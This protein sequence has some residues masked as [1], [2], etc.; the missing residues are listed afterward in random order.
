MKQAPSSDPLNRTLEPPSSGLT[1]DPGGDPMTPQCSGLA[2][3]DVACCLPVA[4]DTLAERCR[5]QRKKLWC[6]LMRPAGCANRAI[7]M[8]R[9]NDPRHD[10]LD[11]LRTKR[12]IFGISTNKDDVRK[13]EMPE[14]KVATLPVD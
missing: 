12:E 7:R 5:R 13:I 3:V 2:P 4:A 11:A 1:P 10:Q 6:S 9:L 8:H 14:T